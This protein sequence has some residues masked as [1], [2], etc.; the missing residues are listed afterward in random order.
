MTSKAATQQHNPY[1][2][3]CSHNVQVEKTQCS[4]TMSF[5]CTSAQL[6]RG[7]SFNNCNATGVVTTTLFTPVTLSYIFYSNVTQNV[8]HG[9][10]ALASLG[11]G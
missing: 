9:P 7:E 6:T 11:D 4:Y 1:D 3:H 8:V 2:Y 5:T 10:A